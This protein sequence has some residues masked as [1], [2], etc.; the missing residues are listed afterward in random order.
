MFGF[1]SHVLMNRERY[2]LS[3]MG[4]FVLTLLTKQFSFQNSRYR[5]IARAQV[6]S[7]KP[8]YRSNDT[9]SVCVSTVLILGE[10]E[11]DLAR[12]LFCTTKMVESKVQNVLFCLKANIEQIGG[13]VGKKEFEK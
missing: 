3:L 13:Y 8:R 7:Q 11:F 10:F 12:L 4:L 9:I 1:T 5:E 6:N 2:T